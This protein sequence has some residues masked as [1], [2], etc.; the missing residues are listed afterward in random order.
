MGPVIRIICDICQINPGVIQVRDRWFGTIADFCKNCNDE[1][2]QECQDYCARQRRQRRGR[3]RSDEIARLELPVPSQFHSEPLEL[4]VVFGSI[5]KLRLYEQVLAINDISWVLEAS[6][7]GDDQIDW[8]RQELMSINLETL[9]TE[10][11]FEDRKAINERYG[12]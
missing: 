1:R 8:L 4:Q 10:D 3:L 6:L 5:N 9:I 7:T 12:F 11:S 2:A